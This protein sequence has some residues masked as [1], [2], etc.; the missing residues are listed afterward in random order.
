MRYVI[1]LRPEVRDDLSNAY[2]WY[3]G[4]KSGLGEDF[5]DSINE[6]LSFHKP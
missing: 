6:L 1:V 4:Q 2:E 3:E 5:I